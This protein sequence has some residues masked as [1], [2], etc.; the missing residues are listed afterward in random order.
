M[1]SLNDY[2]IRSS[3]RLSVC[4][5]VCHKPALTVL[6][7]CVDGRIANRRWRPSLVHDV[8]ERPVS[9]RQSVCPSV[10]LPV[11]HDCVVCRWV[12][13]EQTVETGGRWSKPHVSTT[14]MRGLNALRRA[15]SDGDCCVGLD[16]ECTSG[17]YD[18]A[19]QSTHQR[20]DSQATLGQ[21]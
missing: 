5:S 14:S 13:Y 16:V 10:R 9:V 2:L 19:G 17:Q 8:D 15:I 12:K 11:C 20:A 18:V 6:W 4:L 21:S 3:A 1:R 7:R